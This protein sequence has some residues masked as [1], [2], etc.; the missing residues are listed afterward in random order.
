MMRFM[1]EMTDKQDWDRKVHDPVIAAKWKAEAMATPNLN[2]SQEMADW[3]LEE[4]KCKAVEYQQTGA[5][6]AVDRGIY[7]SDTA[8]SPAIKE[9]LKKGCAVLEDVPARQ[10]DWHPGSDGKVLDLV[11]PSLFPLVY[12]RSKILPDE[13]LSLVDCTTRAG[14]GETIPI[15]EEPEVPPRSLQSLAD[16]PRSWSTKFQ[17]LPCELRF[18]VDGD[19]RVVSY[20]N[21]L[22]PQHHAE[23][24]TTIEQVITKAIPLWDLTLTAARD[25][26]EWPEV[27]RIQYH[28]MLS[29]TEDKGPEPVQRD[30]EDEDDF[31][32]RQIAWERIDRII[33]QPEPPVFRTPEEVRQERNEGS[34]VKPVN[35]ENLREEYHEKGLQVIVKLANIE[36]TPENSQYEGGSW[37]VEG[38]NNEHI[39]ATAI[40]YYDS[41]NITESLLLFRQTTD[42]EV[43]V[44]YEQDDH[45]FL[46]VIFGCEQD[47]AAVQD[48]GDVVAKEGRLITFPNIY[49]HRVAPF[50]LAD[51]TRP[52]HRK[53]LALFL[54]DPTHRIISTANVPPQQRDWWAMEFDNEGPLGAIPPEVR[55]QS[56]TD[57]PISMED[58]KSLRL[59]LMEERTAL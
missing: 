41:D 24:Y 23:L 57:F 15:P 45:E 38:Q 53:I 25:E 50:R 33:I 40:Y 4:L 28:I 6:C 51:G 20:I 8:I 52:G 29:T 26:Q 3:C 37:H 44:D 9:A 54:V 10:K 55:E 35:A 49:Q 46:N 32:M 11:H 47:G 34:S 39:C 21:N 17:W 36:L 48:I 5:V 7:K 16:F 59:E 30:D 13:T 14:E 27:P 2:M 22:H 43:E 31:K 19:A 56:V 58:A 42:N 12:G 1:E 18:G